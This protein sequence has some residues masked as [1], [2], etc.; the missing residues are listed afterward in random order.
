MLTLNYIREYKTEVIRRLHI[1]NFDAEELVEQIIDLDNQRRTN[2]QRQDNCQA[3]MKSLS[4]EIGELF[5]QGKTGEANQAKQKT[6]DLKEEI[7]ALTIASATVETNLNSLL[8]QLPNLP[9][10]SVPE[11]KGATDNLEVKSGGNMPDKENT[12][13]PHWELAKKYDI[14]DFELG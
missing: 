7:K 5:Q 4:K 12:A 11:G 13:L 6:A 1:K 10:D 8:V 3:E 9:H 2:Q 14:I